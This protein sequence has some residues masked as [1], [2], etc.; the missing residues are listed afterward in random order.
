MLQSGNN[1]VNR[2]NDAV[3]CFSKDHVNRKPNIKNLTSNVNGMISLL[4]TRKDIA[5]IYLEI[6]E[7]MIVYKMI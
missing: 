4:G 5:A 1:E 2:M 6:S 7:C 3:E